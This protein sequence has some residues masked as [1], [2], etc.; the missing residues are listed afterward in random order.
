MLLSGSIMFLREF[1]ISLTKLYVG[2]MLLLEL[3]QKICDKS[4]EKL[5]EK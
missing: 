5:F 4:K 3:V 1:I 2:T